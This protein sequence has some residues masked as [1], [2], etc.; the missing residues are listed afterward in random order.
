MPPKKKLKN[1]KVNTQKTDE[2]SAD[3]SDG[4]VKRKPNRSKK[5][6]AAAD[7]TQK[8]LQNKASTEFDDQDFSNDSKTADGKLWNLKIASWNVDGIRAWAK[9]NTNCK[10]SY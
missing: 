6:T 7:K 3:D 8:V 4:E 5:T 2:N 10:Y 9:V 1:E